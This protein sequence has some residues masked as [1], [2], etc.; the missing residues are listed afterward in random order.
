LTFEKHTLSNDCYWIIKDLDDRSYFFF[1]YNTQSFQRTCLIL[2]RAFQTKQ[3]I[4]V[5]VKNN[6]Q[7]DFIL[8]S[9]G[10]ESFFTIREE[11]DEDKIE[12]DQSR[13]GQKVLKNK[14]TS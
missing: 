4:R 12:Q 3:S 11:N 6:G 7:R 2:Q 9:E 1:K 10:S 14:I 5:A 13:V 8:F